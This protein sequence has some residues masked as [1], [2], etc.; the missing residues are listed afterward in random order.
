[1]P[2]Y[3]NAPVK[4]TCPKIDKAIGAL[5]NVLCCVSEEDKENLENAISYS[6]EAQDLLEE[7]RSANEELRAWGND[8]HNEREYWE[9]ETDILQRNNDDLKDEINSLES[10]IEELKQELTENS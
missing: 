4:N 1:M 3:D 9:K 5:H 2:R 10:Y 6:N 7:I 8:M